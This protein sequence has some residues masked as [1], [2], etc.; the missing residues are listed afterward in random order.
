MYYHPNQPGTEGPF[1]STPNMGPIGEHSSYYRSS[2]YDRPSPR[3]PMDPRQEG[4][5]VPLSAQPL[6][7]SFFG[8][9]S[10]SASFRNDEG[11]DSPHSMS[12]PS[13]AFV[14]V[15][16][17]PPTVAD[18]VV[19]PT[20]GFT[21]SKEGI[22]E[23]AEHKKRERCR[24][25]CIPCCMCC[26]WLRAVIIIFIV[27][28]TVGL[29]LFFVWPRIPSVSIQ[30]YTVTGTPQLSTGA[31]WQAYVPFNVTVQATSTNYINY[32][33]NRVVVN[34][35]SQASGLLLGGG[36]TYNLDILAQT[37]SFLNLTLALNYT[38]STLTDPTLISVFNA[39]FP[40]QVGGTKSEIGLKVSTALY[41]SLIQWLG[42]VPTFSFNY[43]VQCP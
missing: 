29:V 22:L 11:F 15:T 27:L 3:P 14:P 13:Y 37:T 4:F 10:G 16:A 38:A 21:G 9:G 33:L 32:H 1:T 18:N 7:S 41:I 36:T 28:I 34:L 31:V 2:L 25:F 24:F 40:S 17:A 39:C 23:K 5:D 8:S 19:F 26:T 20:I 30:G 6:R 43:N 35:T 42:I 12:R